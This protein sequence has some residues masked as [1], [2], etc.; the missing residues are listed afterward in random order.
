MKS[1]WPIDAN[2]SLAG[3]AWV[4]VYL[5]TIS[6]TIGIRPDH[7]FLSLII[8]VFLVY[9]RKWGKLFLIDWAPFILFWVAYDMMRGVADSI[10]GQINVEGPFQLEASLFGWLTPAVVPAFYFQQFQI[11]HEGT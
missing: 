10:R 4:F 2:I 1:R 7:A 8:F 3:L 5:Y 9:G 11:T 6:R